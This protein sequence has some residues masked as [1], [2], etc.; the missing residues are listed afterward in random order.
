VAGTDGGFTPPEFPA[1]LPQETEAAE[2]RRPGLAA[3][4][5]LGILAGVFAVGLV[6]VFTLG[7]PTS[8]GPNSLV[9]QPG[10][11]SG[12][13]TA[14]PGPSASASASAPGGATDQPA[15][16][17]TAGAGGSSGTGAATVAFFV[18]ECV[19][20][21][22]SDADFSVEQSA[23]PGAQFKIIQSFPNE[24]GKV[25]ADQSQCY[26]VN[27]NDS[28]FENGNA[29]DGYT[30]YCMN[31]LTGSYSPRRAA[32][33][34][35]LDSTGAYEVDCTGAKAYWIVIGRLDDTTNTKSC[36]KFG[37]YDYSYYYTATPTFVL[38]V[39][40]YHA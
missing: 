1:G 3:G 6:L 12:A 28:E 16:T 21:T 31:S 32:V 14:D 15:L 36:S 18:G 26:A 37:S 24:S 25:S 11:T 17:P 20:T 27:G 39:N 2:A 40:R 19:D 4:A 34:N 13:R 10:V 30:L 7:Q 35:C 33:N 29:A 8:G 38:C 5:A 23:C 9:A 22:G